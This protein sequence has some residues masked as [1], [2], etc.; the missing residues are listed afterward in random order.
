MR[1]PSSAATE[2]TPPATPR[3]GGNVEHGEELDQ[4][5]TRELQEELG[6][7]IAQTDGANC[8]GWSTSASPGPAPPLR[9]AN[10]T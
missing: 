7:D 10:S 8:C 4:A 5:L 2:P 1:S 6:L 9:P 3:P